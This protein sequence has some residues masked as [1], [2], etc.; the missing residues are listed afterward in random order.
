MISR[1]A[2]EED[3]YV[4]FARSIPFPSRLEML[5]VFNETK[6]AQA[7]V[8]QAPIPQR[9]RL[10]IH[11]WKLNQH[12]TDRYW[13]GTEEEKGMN[14]A[15]SMRIAAAILVPRFLGDVTVRG[16]RRRPAARLA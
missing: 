10:E 14:Q 9:D 7:F 12:T 13:T 11:R 8:D 3:V 5:A 2:G 6:L 15:T 4:I 1:A 16:T